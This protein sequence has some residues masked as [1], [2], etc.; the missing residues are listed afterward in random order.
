MRNQEGRI[1]SIEL[2]KE[3]L[4]ITNSKKIEIKITKKTTLQPNVE[5]E[6]IE[7]LCGEEECSES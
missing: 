3:K 2:I 6:V 5:L 4:G 1:G 7:E